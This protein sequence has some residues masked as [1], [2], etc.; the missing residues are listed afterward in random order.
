MR[1]CSAELG[2]CTTMLSRLCTQSAVVREILLQ[3]QSGTAAFLPC[4][5]A[6]RAGRSI[7]VMTSIGRL[8]LASPA[9]ALHAGRAADPAARPAA[10]PAAGPA[11]AARAPPH[12]PTPLWR[13]ALRPPP[14]AAAAAGND[15]V[16]PRQW[17]SARGAP[18]CDF[19]NGQYDAA[20]QYA[21]LHLSSLCT[22]PHSAT[23]INK[24]LALQCAL[25]GSPLRV[26][27]LSGC[28]AT[29]RAH[30]HL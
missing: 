29:H 9:V 11:L 1:G 4:M 7:A 18:T 5:A 22:S 13:P 20:H 10:G 17:C 8:P 6:G 2:S 28:P 27:S 25:W 16:T 30:L 19:P 15:L 14:L 12:A 24:A 3:P 26:A 21:E 23:S